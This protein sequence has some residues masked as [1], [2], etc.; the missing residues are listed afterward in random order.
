LSNSN[1]TGAA[2]PSIAQATSK[3]KL[4]VFAF[5][6]SASKQ[7]ATVVLTR[8]YYDMGLDSAQIAT[9]VMRGEK[10]ASIPFFQS[11]K[12]RL[13]LNLVSAQKLGLTIPESL[14]KSADQ[15][16]DK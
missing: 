7:G 16:I 3:A 15:V 8:D 13:Y 5:L 1:L 2:F 12:S 9:R 6:G 4:P 14:I 10:P 11:T